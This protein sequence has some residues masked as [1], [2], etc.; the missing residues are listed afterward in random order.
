MKALTR[1]IILDA[2]AQR[3]N[4]MDKLLADMKTTWL[5]AR[6]RMENPDIWLNEK[7]DCAID[8][9]AEATKEKRNPLIRLKGDILLQN[10]EQIK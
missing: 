1:Q 9:F 2:Q 7:V 6:S 10:L 4:N 5:T 3:W 8:D